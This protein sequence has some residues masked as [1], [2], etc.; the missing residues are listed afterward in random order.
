[1][2]TRNLLL[3]IITI[4]GFRSFV[5]A[6]PPED[7]KAIFMSRCAGCHNVNK[8]LTGPALAGVHERRSIDWIIKFVKSSQTLVKNGD[9]DAVTLYEKFNKVQ[10]PDHSDLSTENIKNI[11]EYIKTESV[12]TGSE[13][14]FAKPGKKVYPYTPLSLSKNYGLFVS[15]G[16]VVFLLVMTLLFVVRLTDF[17]RKTGNG[18]FK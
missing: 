16:I 18:V 13:T 4:L 14:P 9:K 3:V 1:M 12:P 5:N 2:K 17:R 10:M 15:Y 7:G 8:N 11:V 6:T